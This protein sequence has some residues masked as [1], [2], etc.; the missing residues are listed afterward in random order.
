MDFDNDCKNGI[1]YADDGSCEEFDSDVEKGA[2]DYISEVVKYA[3]AHYGSR[4]VIASLRPMFWSCVLLRP[5]GIMRSCT[6]HL[7]PCGSFS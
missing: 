1:E 6:E 4:F 2:K 5:S 3:R 7:P